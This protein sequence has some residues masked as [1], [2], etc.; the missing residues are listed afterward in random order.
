VRRTIQEAFVKPPATL[1]AE[2]TL[3]D[4]YQTTVPD[5]IRRVLKLR[6]RDRIRYLVRPDGSVNVERVADSADDADPVVGAFLGFLARD[7]E[8]HPEQVRA[9]DA[10]LRA[11]VEALVGHV[12]VDLDEP[13][14]PDDE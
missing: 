6:R 10:S 11:R 7:L 4:R 14:S 2:S 13:L 12:D 1:Q 9:L 5:P 8:R 3:T